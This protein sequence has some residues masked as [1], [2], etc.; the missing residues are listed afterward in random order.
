MR[1]FARIAIASVVLSSFA[2]FGVGGLI[3]TAGA[4]STGVTYYVN[5]ATDDAL[6]YATDCT[7]PTNSDCGIDD[8]INAFDQDTTV[9]DA[10]TI[11]FASDVSTFNVTDP[12]QLANQTS[13]VTV[14]FD[15]NGPS[16]TTV[17]GDD[18]NT[19]FNDLG[20]HATISNL[21]ITGGDGGVVVGEMD[22]TVTL[23]DDTLS[24]NPGGAVSIGTDSGLLMTD[25]TVTNTVLADE[26][27]GVDTGEDSGPISITNDTFFNSGINNVGSDS[28]MTNDTLFNSEIANSGGI[29]LANSI[30]DSPTSC[31]NFGSI[32]DGGYNVES[33]ATCGLTTSLVNNGSI[34]LA[35]S[36]AANGSSGPETLA[37]ESESSAFEEVPLAD[38]TVTTDQRGV[39]RPGIASENC[40]AGAYEST[41]N[42]YYVNAATDDTSGFATDCSS[43]T[44]SD[45]GIDDAI[46]AFDNDTAV[47]DHDTIVFA[48]D[49]S[50][51]NVTVPTPLYAGAT[52]LTLNI[53]GNGPG[54][55][56]VSGDDEN[57]VFDDTGPSVTISNLTITG[58]DGGVFLGEMAGTVTLN[59]DTLS[60]NPGGAVSIQPDSGLLM[61]DDTVSNTVSADEGGGVDIGGDSGPITMTNDTFFNSGID[62]GGPGTVMTNDTLLNSEI[63]NSGGITLAN[64]ILDSPPSDDSSSCSNLGSITDGGYNVESDATCGLTTSLVNNGSIDLATSLA[65]NGSSGPE[66]LAI[67]EDS[68]AFREVPL[69]SCTITTDERGVSRPGIAGENCDAG[70]LEANPT[71]ATLLLTGAP[72]VGDNTYGVYLVLPTDASS[73]SQPV[74]VTDSAGNS[75]EAPLTANSAT[76]YSGTCLIDNEAANDTVTATYNATLSDPNFLETT[77]NTLSVPGG[78][79]SGSGSGSGSGPVLGPSP[80]PPAPVKPPK[81]LDSPTSRAEAGAAPRLVSGHQRHQVSKFRSSP[82]LRPSAVSRIPGSPF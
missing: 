13:G 29:T 11:V 39:S 26:G 17:N 63:L 42:T 75:C 48:P 3:D 28:V 24:N 15:G 21:T 82:R 72:A 33:D 2:S 1:V 52:R 73:P 14:Q 36:L 41:G 38:C 18:A 40:D 44:N 5:A 16:T 57:T 62:N 78:A 77:S 27:D 12:A 65:A 32:T 69:G 47:G 7:S 50:T 67:N 9:G 25:D 43:P 8:A 35:T 68:S 45:C 31:S 81:R 80:P 23:T 20:A 58:G 66:T 79:G 34:D 64:S 22:G 49:V 4:T 60:N 61:T 59:D 56:T 19:V 53:Q 46:N 37:I 10:D 51:F 70:A 74:V 30:L 6:G 76:V 71:A 55:T 54:A